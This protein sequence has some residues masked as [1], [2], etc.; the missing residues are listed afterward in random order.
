M[1]RDWGL[2]W[3]NLI[4]LIPLIPG[5][6]VYLRWR[7]LK[8]DGIR[9]TAM[10]EHI[11]AAYYGSSQNI[12]LVWTDQ[13]GKRR[14]KS[15]GIHDRARNPIRVHNLAE[16]CYDDYRVVLVHHTPFAAIPLM[17]FGG[18]IIAFITTLVILEPYIY[19]YH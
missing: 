14:R 7:W 12:T 1:D 4:G 10:V 2:L 15:I 9:C 6:V 8:R 5:V 19:S 18:L 13:N 17:V 3:I 16:I 11:I